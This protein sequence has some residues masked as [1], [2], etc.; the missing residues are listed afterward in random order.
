MSKTK[1]TSYTLARGR[2]QP[3]RK[4]LT[5]LSA[6]PLKD[7][8]G[9][10]VKSE[11]GKPVMKMLA[12]PK[13]PPVQ[14]V[15]EP[16]EDIDLTEEE[17]GY[18]A[19]AIKGGFIVPTNRDAKGRQKTTRNVPSPEAADEIAKLEKKIE[20]LAADNAQLKADLEAATAPK[21]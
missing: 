15:F 3:Y 10:T 5:Y 19:N 13:R 12:D 21:G 11:D 20:D 7:A 14:L 16:D 1:A 4:T 2:T 8:E 9:K 18:L 6:Q 17:V